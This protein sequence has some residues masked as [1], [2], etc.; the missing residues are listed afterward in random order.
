MKSL[1]SIKNISIETI[2]NLSHSKVFRIFKEARWE[3]GKVYC[4]HCGSFNK[5]N[6]KNKNNEII[7][8]RCRDCNK[9]FSPTSDTIFH[10]HK[11]PL[12][13]Y[14]LAIF[15]FSNSSKGMS[16]L[17]LA[18]DLNIG[19]KSAYVLLQKLRYSLFQQYTD[20]LNNK[21]KGVVQV[22]GAYIN[23]KVKH[24]NKKEDRVDRR[25]TSYLTQQCI[26]V[27]REIDSEGR[28]K[29]SYAFITRSENSSEVMN[30]I[31]TYVEEDTLI[32]TDEHTAYKPLKNS[33]FR[34]KSVNHSVEYQ[35]EEGINTNQ[36]ESYFSRLRR[37]V[38]GQH[39]RLSKKYLDL[40]VNEITYR[41]NMRFNDNIHMLEDILRYSLRCNNNTI[42]NHYSQ[43]NNSEIVHFKDFIS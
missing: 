26:I 27:L 41:E 24:P 30:L 28:S 29:R 25:K 2:S 40:Y 33:K 13:T 4:I 12:K 36:A 37:M 18:R 6:T 31:N 21:L 35:N 16:S 8:Y 5:R 42:F 7:G 39:H 9:N 1:Y 10:N 3:N 34:Y 14:L 19:D 23:H 22:D 17:Q 20:L 32:I 43:R 38:I 11:Y 15:L